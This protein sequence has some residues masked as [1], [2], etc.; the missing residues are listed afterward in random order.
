MSR[1]STMS[2]FAEPNHRDEPKVVAFCCECTEPLYQGQE[3]ISFEGELFCDRYC[4]DVYYNVREI[5][6]GED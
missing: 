3:A 1:L 5:T 2:R 6:V 4:F